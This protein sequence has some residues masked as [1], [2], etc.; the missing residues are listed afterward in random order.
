MGRFNGNGQGQKATNE[1][2]R[3]YF[4]LRDIGGMSVKTAAEKVGRKKSWGYEQER[5]RVIEAMPPA[6]VGRRKDEEPPDITQAAGLCILLVEDKEGLDSDG[7]EKTISYKAA[8]MRLLERYGI[9]IVFPLAKLAVFLATARAEDINRSF[10][11][12]LE[13]P[14]TPAD[15]FET[16][17]SVLKADG[18]PLWEGL[19]P[20]LELPAEIDFYYREWR[21]PFFQESA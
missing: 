13:D 2:I 6:G 11:D 18:E 15:V 9:E 7:D 4:Q 10:G 17:A 19:E 5:K 12:A 16:I 3:A 14:V 8:F 21:Y 20:D 1:E